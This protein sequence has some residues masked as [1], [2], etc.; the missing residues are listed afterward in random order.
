MIIN[1]ILDARV[2]AHGMTEDEAMRLMLERG[3]RS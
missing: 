1:A 3:Y 2:H